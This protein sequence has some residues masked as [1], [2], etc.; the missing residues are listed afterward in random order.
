MTAV[1]SVQQHPASADA[2]IRHGWSLVPI[3]MGTKGPTH[4]GWNLKDN[5]LKSQADLP[6]GY[7]I[8]L[9][10]AYSGT[11]A[12]DIDSWTIAGTILSEHGVNLQ[13]LYEAPDAVIINSGK[14]GHGKLLYA[15]PLGIALPSKKIIHN[16][17]VVYE[18]RC[19]TSSGLTVQ[20][21]LPPSIHPEV[22]KP[23]QWAG[24]GHWTRLPTIPQPLL[25]LWQSMLAQDQE[26]TISTDTPV[27]ASWTEIQ[28]AIDHIN[29]DCSRDEWINVG[30]A[31][32]WAGSQTG[33]L[34]Q[35]LA[36]WNEWSSQGTK[37]P[38][39][40]ALLTQWHSFRPDKAT[41]V[42]LGSLFHIAKQHGWT[43]P[44]PDVS[45]L[46][47]KVGP[48]KLTPDDLL[49]GLRAPIPDLDMNLLPPVLATR[50][51]Q[52][53]IEMGCDPLLP[54][55]AG[56]AAICG[57]VDAQSR[58][59]LM[60][61]YQVPPV[62]WIM[63][64]GSPALKKTPASKPMLQVLGEI[65]ALDRPRYQKEL[66]AWEGRE[67]A[68][69]KAKKNFLDW[70][71]SPEALL[72]GDQA[73][74]VPEA[75]VKPVP[76][77]ITVDDV[78]S[79][80]L[81]RSAAERPR[82]LLCHLDEMAAWIN[83]M[84]DRTSGDDRSAWVKSYEANKYEMERVGAGS[85]YSENFAVSIYGNVQPK[86]YWDSV[87]KLSADGLLQRFIP[88]I[89]RNRNWGVGQPLPDY[90][91]NTDAWE[92]TVR[93]AFSLPVQTYKLSPEAFDL[94]REFQ[95]W[96]N[97]AKQDE[98]LLQ[99]GD[100]Y[101]TAFGKLEGLVGRIAFVWHIIE[102]P[103][104]LTVSEYL[105][106]RVIK[107][108]RT[109]V[110]PALRYAF[111]DTGPSSFDQW[112][113][114]HVIQ[115]SDKPTITLSDIKRSARRQIGEKQIWMQDQIVFSAMKPLEEGK[116]VI[117]MDDGSKEH[118]HIAEWA[119]NPG[120]RTM[121]SDYL[122]DVIRAKQRQRED[123]Y[124]LSPNAPPKVYGADVLTDDE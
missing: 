8:G 98:V 110:I 62:L 76:V 26:R 60:P 23:Y 12:L 15:M 90:M 65:E 40:R 114:E 43:R 33:Q 52:I 95:H 31:L 53:G 119:I 115:H 120:C 107:F 59:E 39:H 75:P 103:F 81:V 124:K 45:E 16:G 89:L 55:F 25:D 121:F 2:Y 7:G 71:A 44:Q 13:A 97:D 11:M 93:L 27:D 36:L 80:K 54:A 35:A 78:T 117:R 37:Y 18:L 14:P 66:L 64:I 87:S 42:K 51:E 32:H 1:P 41:A 5:A 118:L 106:Q 109:Y 10:H 73:P 3:S 58:L 86:V 38:G 105:M 74:H 122:K 29:P 24:R 70:S 34:D 99:A 108:T 63:T 79:Q 20:D 83:K 30:M 116:W 112:V 82:G 46:F 21:V 69:T 57:A 123:I 104:C 22:G 48:P 68:Y 111:S 72:G 17:I 49:A 9:A 102:T 96:Y 19:A 67:A 91:T 100:V 61:R 113:V 77:K 6:P 85:I 50:A 92:N 88:V 84:S 4:K 47:K 28:Q 101:L 94:Y 56:M